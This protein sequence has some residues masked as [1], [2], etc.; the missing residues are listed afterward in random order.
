MLWLAYLGDCCRIGLRMVYNKSF[1]HLWWI[2]HVRILFQGLESSERLHHRGWFVSRLRLARKLGVY[3]CFKDFGTCKY[4][5]VSNF[6]VKTA[7]SLSAR[8]QL[9]ERGES[10]TLHYR[11]YIT[12]LGEMGWSWTNPASRIYPGWALSQQARD[13]K[14]QTVVM[15]RLW[16]IFLHNWAPLF[17][18]FLQH[19]CTKDW[20][21]SRTCQI[22]QPVNDRKW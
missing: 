7:E 20:P 8:P 21:W 12:L 11:Q 5:Q 14:F 13:S 15:T 19:E 17:D 3:T 22:S 9:Q 2:W 4:H 1:E 10:L 16:Q 6:G 18:S